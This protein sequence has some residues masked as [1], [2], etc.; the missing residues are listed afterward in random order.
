MNKIILLLICCTS[1]MLTNG[2]AVYKASVDERPVKTIYNDE[3]IT[4]NIM[5]SYLQDDTQKILD[6]SPAS[7]KGDVY[8]VGEYSTEAQKQRAIAIARKTSG[9]RSVTSF[10]L[11]KKVNDTCGTTDNLEIQAR[12]DS[13]LIG[14]SSIWSTNVDVKTVQC[15]VVLLGIV[16]SQAE[17]TKA[18]AHARSVPGVRSV[19]SYLRVK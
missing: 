14:D 9:V 15:N 19:R 10:L 4:A 8:L 5:S 2:C 3:V 11:P 7:Y 6:I 18:I 1:V 13:K 12:V 16:G 17:V